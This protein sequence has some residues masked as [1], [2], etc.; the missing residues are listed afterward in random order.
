VVVCTGETECNVRVADHSGVNW[1]EFCQIGFCLRKRTGITAT[2]LW[3]TTFGFGV[4][5]G[6]YVCTRL[7]SRVHPY[8]D[9]PFM[10]KPLFVYALLPGF[11]AAE[12][13]KNRWIEATA[14]LLANVL[15]YS[16]AAFFLM[17]A[18][19]AVADGKFKRSRFSKEG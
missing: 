18:F 8:R 19:R 13:F 16:L 4:V 6:L 3:S 1:A 10:P 9:L 5:G 2:A 11:V 15:L 14:F 7:M 12:P 17:N